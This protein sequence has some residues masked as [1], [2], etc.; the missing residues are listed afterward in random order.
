MGHDNVFQTAGYIRLSRE[1]GDKEESDSITNQRQMLEEYISQKNEFVL[2]NMFSDDGYTGTNFQRP[3]F[4]RMMEEIEKGNIECVIVKDLSR[5]GRDYIETGRYLERVF[6]QKGIRFIALTDGI[7]SHKQAYD[8][9]LPIKNIF[10]EQYARDISKKIQAAFKTKQKSG[11]FI[12]AFA[13][14]GYRKSAGDKN[15]LVIDP[16]AASVVKRI[17]SLYL[18]GEGKAGIAKIL[19]NEGI[20]CPSEYKKV[21]GEHYKN[22][23]KLQSTTYWTYSTIN[24]ILNNEL[25]IGNMVQGKKQ[26]R[27]KHKQLQVKK[28]NWIVVENT[29]E[30]IIEKGDWEKVQE[31]LERRTRETDMTSGRN[32]FAGF[33]KCGDCK[34]SMVKHAWRNA[35]GTSTCSFYCGTYKRVGKQYCTAHYIRFEALEEIVRNDLNLILKSVENLESIIDTELKNTESDSCMSKQERLRI[36]HEL[37]KVKRMKKSVYEDYC[38]GILS[39]EEFMSYR[40]D[41]LDKEELYTRQ[42]E[43]LEE[44]DNRENKGRLTFWL[45]YLKHFGEV[46]MLDRQSIAEMIDSIYI[47]END[48]IKIRY[49][50]SDELETFFTS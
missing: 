32:I 28:E 45:E 27:M 25:Y 4:Q 41:Y 3:G 9:L 36:K 39:K 14:Y 35:D 7:D 5:F 50:F 49:C 13:S 11:E 37:E 31:L 18:Q 38:E 20:L 30:G 24:K 2:Y 40:K 26:Q 17:F 44:A 43:A 1:D 33:L 12:G 47:F 19:N 10:N 6:P 42:G 48:R 46:K 21:N 22:S 29:H 16:Y 8:M 23:R 34:R 15:R